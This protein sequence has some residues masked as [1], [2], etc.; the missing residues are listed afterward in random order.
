M[1]FIS[2]LEIPWLSASESSGYSMFLSSSHQFEASAHAIFLSPMTYSNSIAIT[3]RWQHKQRMNVRVPSLTTT[4]LSAHL[5][6]YRRNST[7]SS[8]NTP[9][10]STILWWCGVS[11][12]RGCSWQRCQ[13]HSN[14]I[15]FRWMEVMLHD[16]WTY[17]R[18]KYSY[19]VKL[20]L[21]SG[22]RLTRPLGHSLSLQLL[23]W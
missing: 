3:C 21:K 18:R 16:S 14:S 19:C 11:T 17:C 15:M 7:A 22:K 13:Y 1:N 12:A 10:S 2:C 4:W 9:T 5:P 6:W 8:T 20:K 23:R